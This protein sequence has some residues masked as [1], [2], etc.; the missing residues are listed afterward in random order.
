MPTKTSP[1]RRTSR[2]PKRTR[3]RS[4]SKGSTRSRSATRSKAK[5][6]PKTPVRQILS[7]HARD[8][9][10]IFLVVVSLLGILG[11]WFGAAGP[12]G[13]FLAWL[14]KGAFGVAAYVAP[15]LGAYWGLVL[16]RDTAREER[17]RMFIGFCVLVAGALGIL[18]L[19][20]GRPAPT[21]GYDAVAVAGGVFGA[22][23]AH[24]LTRVLSPIGAAIVC[25]GLLVLGLLIFTGTP[26]ASVWGRMR[27]FFTA[28]DVGEEDEEVAR[29]APPA[30]LELRPPPEPEA[31]KRGRV[32]RLREAF[33]LL[34]PAPDDEVVIVPELGGAAFEVGTRIDDAGT[35][36]REPSPSKARPTR[37][38]TVETESGPYQLPPLDL[39]RV[40]PPSN[41]D[42]T[43]ERNMQT[44]LELTL[45]TFGV[46]A[47]VSAA[48]RGPTV[49]MYEVEVASGTKVNKVLG[50]SSDIAYALA[51]PDVR[52][53]AP[54][55][56]KSAIGIEVPNKH[57]DFVMLGDILRSP[58]A[59]EATHPLEVAL[60]KD[61]HGRAR[62]VNLAQMPHLLIAGATGAGKSSLV[63]SFV[64]S[65]LMRTTPEDVRL[66]LVDPKR[67]ELSHFADVPHLLSPVIVHPK[68]AAEALQWIAREM[69]Q[70][71]EML[72]T[73][74]ARD[75]DGYEEGLA[76]GT[77]RIPPGLE[78]RFEHL[79]YIV[80]VIDELADLMMVAPR[81]VEDAICRIAQMARAVGIHL[82]VAT[83]RPSVDVVTG[84]I[85]ANI[86]S[87]IAL[88]TSS[89]ADSR[90]ILDMNGAEKLVGHGD[91]LFAPSSISKPV[92]L[93]G[94][95]VTEQEI[96]AISDFIRGQREV[97]YENSVEG[98][99]LP[100]SEA[101]ASGGGLGG[102]DELLEQAA[103]LVIRS[104]LGS[105]SMLQRKLKVGFARA[106]RLMDLMED[107]GIVGPSQGSKARDVLVTWEE[108]E[109]RRS[110]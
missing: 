23:V 40:A 65:L 33:G 47:R 79:P 30:Q 105:T 73:V 54:I 18:S 15:L 80:V 101:E 62:M 27:D 29:P 39:L 106:G 69:E 2:A 51:T 59:I 94:A 98:L 57:R 19:L 60:G 34:E 37:G 20:G 96:F 61:V 45:H 99:G 53:M 63:N 43:D 77:L 7:P 74:G 14:T 97:V 25:L 31:P 44:A 42:L 100:P 95:W 50:L 1:S 32:A 66:I 58:A 55:P 84:L 56:G 36:E 86:P 102:D 11:I 26:I 76:A 110:A 81:D 28:A 48:H 90:V 108:W 68:R 41:A 88:M 35:T 93:Q 83:Q 92:R 107:Q 17:V 70:R 4:T 6:P 67:V 104:Q 87:R 8:A 24:P 71:Y 82:V 13:G 103:E 9:L 22:V 91:M 21:D 89:Q 46:D 3:A 72:A 75:I 49:T 12:V 64:T 10:G 85:K 109:E 38:R 16:L 5:Q 52:I 78:H